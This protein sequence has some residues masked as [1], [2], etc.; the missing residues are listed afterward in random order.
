VTYIALY[1]AYAAVWLFPKHKSQL[2]WAYTAVWFAYI[3]LSVW[4]WLA[5]SVLYQRWFQPGRRTL[6]RFMV[7]F[8][9][10]CALPFVQLGWEF[11]HIDYLAEEQQHPQ[12]PAIETEK[13]LA[14]QSSLLT[15]TL[16]QLENAEHRSDI[17][18]YFVAY[19]PDDAQD[20]FMKEALAIQKL[21]DERFG[22]VGKSVALIN[23]RATT[24]SHLWAMQHHL[25]AVLKTIGKR[26]GPNDLL[27]LYITSHGSRQHTLS[28]DFGFFQLE[29]LDADRLDSLLKAAAIPNTA[30]FISACYSGG[31]I[32]KLSAPNRFIATAT[33][34]THTSFGCDSSLDYT[35]FGKAIF[36]EALRHTFDYSQAF[37]SALPVIRQRELKDGYDPSNP[38]M[39]MGEAIAPLLAR[40]ARTLAEQP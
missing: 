11:F 14:L 26:M 34:A 7:G 40:L 10:V 17:T 8:A 6:Y 38:Q 35:Y 12:P 16:R 29:G 28:A 2:G 20:V 21:M 9:C 18:H 1:L 33:D 23:H 27:T 19:A 15:Q 13:N 5:V 22:T 3:A 24:P 32:P 37:Q 36:D 30:L 39:F 31:L 4:G 25:E